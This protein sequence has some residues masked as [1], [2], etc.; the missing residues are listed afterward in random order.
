VG[1]VVAFALMMAVAVVA[2]DAGIK[3]KK[4]WVVEL[5][6]LK[7]DWT[8]SWA[9]DIND[10]GMV[11]GGFREKDVAGG[12]PAYWKKGDPYSLNDKIG[13]PDDFD[14]ANG[15]VMSMNNK[16][17][18]AGS[19]WIGWNQIAVRWDTGKGTVANLHPADDYLASG[20]WGINA[21]GDVCGFLID[22]TL[23]EGFV[24]VPYVW[25]HCGKKDRALDTGDLDEG[26]TTA[27]NAR[28]AVS[29]YAFPSTFAEI[30]PVFW[31]NKGKMT[32]LFDDVDDAIEDYDIAQGFAMDVHENGMVVGDAIAF[33]DDGSI[34]RWA[35]TWTESGGVKLLDKDDADQA[36]PWKCVGIRV[37]GTLG[38]FS[39][40]D[41]DPAVWTL[42]KLERIPEPKDYERGEASSVDRWGMVA[43]Y[44]FPADDPGI[45]F[46]NPENLIGWVAYKSAEKK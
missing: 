21:R 2:A 25:S 39:D 23:E 17:Q 10:T 19:L 38:A 33:L 7:K 5:L 14:G 40:V 42:G 36:T 29:G 11:G 31:D 12:F 1:C 44:S 27:I 15:N 34:L 37:S 22:G 8:G 43:G 13:T 26:W 16:G 32:D 4:V 18:I 35:W 20:A 41:M 3:L 30:H 28:G 46:G 9:N 24:R 6:D 45:P